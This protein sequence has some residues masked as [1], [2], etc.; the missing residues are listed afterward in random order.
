M[1]E[2]SRQSHGQG[3]PQKAPILD[4]A[5]NNKR[6]WFTALPR[7]YRQQ[8]KI[9]KQLTVHSS[10]VVD[11]SFGGGLRHRIGAVNDKQ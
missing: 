2:E 6:W 8:N 7:Y 3:C 9:H 11:A 1:D 4:L 5:I 10:T